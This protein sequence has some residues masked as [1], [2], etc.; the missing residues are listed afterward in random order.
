MAKIDPITAKS[1]EVVG[2]A[3]WSIDDQTLTLRV[4]DLK[5]P[6][7]SQIRA[8]DLP[9][10]VKFVEV[11]YSTKALTDA[12]S[13]LFATHEKWAQQV[14]PWGYAHADSDKGAVTIGVL[15]S[16]LEAWR[17]AVRSVDVGVPIILVPE[18][19]VT[20]VEEDRITD[21]EPWTG[22]IFILGQYYSGPGTGV[23]T[24]T[25]GFNWRRWSGLGNAGS[26]ANHCINDFNTSPATIHMPWFNGYT[27]W[28]TPV[29]TSPA[30]DA[31]LLQVSGSDYRP[32]VFVGNASTNDARAVVAAASSDVVGEQVAL[33]GGITGGPVGTVYAINATNAQGV[34]VTV[35]TSHMTQEGDSGAP[36]LKTYTDGTVLAKGQHS[37]AIPYGGVLR[38]TYSPVTKISAKVSASILVTP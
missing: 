31:A 14:W 24:C 16:Q 33:S 19:S 36:W 17:A 3:S 7:V 21:A 8:L 15:S 22:G 32:R 12:I 30:S 27:Q 9:I 34:W 4:T 26:T 29:V 23:K 10:Q 1:P 28:G 2:E 37:G 6:V 18:E 11:A 5:A 13:E 35:M 25:A 38:S 20:N